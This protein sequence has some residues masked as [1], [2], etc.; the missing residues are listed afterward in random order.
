M[1]ASFG[2]LD[3]QEI[4]EDVLSLCRGMNLPVREVY[5]SADFKEEVYQVEVELFKEYSSIEE[6][7]KEELEIESRLSE[8]YGDTL[9]INIVSLDEEE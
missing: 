4:K 7:L 1:C 9:E 3:I 2:E 5:V 8:R 6:L